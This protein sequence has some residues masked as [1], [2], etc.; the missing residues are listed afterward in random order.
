MEQHA[1]SSDLIRG[2]IDTIILHTL[3]S[4]DKF[5]QQISEAIE[6]KSGGEYK[7]NQ[8]TLYSSL[9]RLESLKHVSSYWF[10]SVSGRRKYFKLTDLGKE[11][12][13]SNLSSWSYSR[14]I[15]DKLMDC[16]QQPIYKVEYVEKIVSTPVT[17]SPVNNFVEKIEQ[18]TLNTEQLT[19]IKDEKQ[20]TISESAS[21]VYQSTLKTEDTQNKQ[22]INFR[23]I[24]NGLIKSTVVQPAKNEKES[25][26]LETLQKT[27]TET[28]IEQTEKL[29]FNDTITNINYNEQKSNNNGKIDF[30]DLSLKAA[31]EGYKIRISSKD[32]V[33][34]EGTLF[35]NKLN[36]FSSVALLFL[37][38]A[39]LIFFT[40]KFNDL[41]NFNFVKVA[42]ISVFILIYPTIT[43]I[44]YLN[45]P[46]RKSSKKIHAD[47]ILTSAIAL[48]NLSL[49]TFAANLIAGVNF[50]NIESILAS[51]V[52]PIVV[53]LDVFA[54][55]VIKYFLIG[56]FIN[57]IYI[58]KK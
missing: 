14:A 2:H 38:V 21:E 17:E 43:I 26:N 7:I 10:D 35:I 55:F 42:L 20:E 54:Y 4:G 22:E 56:V 31:K 19:E 41:L 15:I 30:G 39:E 25:V 28:P 12:V 16:A 23:N 47:I 49:I 44:K 45:K 5:A 33:I 34:T 40:I 52:L 6:E 57:K 9:K 53:Y 48:F 18:Q 36:A 8:A 27:E 50:S 46:E 37:M 13:E 32:S 11:N 29:K 58:L 3:L 24:L 1:I 51:F